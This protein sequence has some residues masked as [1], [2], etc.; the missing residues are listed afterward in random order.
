MDRIETRAQ[1]FDWV[2]YRAQIDNEWA[3]RAFDAFLMEQ[4]VGKARVVWAFTGA[5][6][7]VDWGAVGD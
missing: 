2:M 7:A 3:V 4:S 1:L 6:Q 5:R